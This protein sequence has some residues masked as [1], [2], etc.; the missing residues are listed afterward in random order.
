MLR[1]G[2]LAPDAESDKPIPCTTAYPSVVR[3]ILKLMTGLTIGLAA[4]AFLLP[5]RS[6]VRVEGLLPAP[7]ARVLDALAGLPTGPSWA[8]WAPALGGR[9]ETT[10]QGEDGV[11]FG[12]KGA[13]HRRAAIQVME[14]EAGTRIIWTDVV[15]HG[16]DPIGRLEGVWLRPARVRY[17]LE[18]S[19]SGL[20]RALE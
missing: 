19:L 1:A 8:V 17:E 12:I 13:P 4:L 10:S 6:E 20:R 2:I 15:H 18:R 16:L 9:L 11:W 14:A 3:R 7:K 5:G